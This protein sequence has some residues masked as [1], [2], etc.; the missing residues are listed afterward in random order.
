[1]TNVHYGSRALLDLAEISD[2]I[3]LDSPR[4]AENFV[5]QLQAKA[6]RIALAPKIYTR[7]DDLESGLRS[8]AFGN[9]LILFRIVDDGIDVSRVVY[10]ARD[11]PRLF[12]T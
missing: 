10:G 6:A 3:A 12:E 4:N 11:L 5:A 8:A 1:M 9:Y 7:R 2:R